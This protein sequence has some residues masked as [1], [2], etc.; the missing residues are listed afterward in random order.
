MPLTTSQILDLAAKPPDAGIAGHCEALSRQLQREQQQRQAS[1]GGPIGAAQAEFLAAVRGAPTGPIGD[2]VTYR[3]PGQAG[4]RVT[5]MPKP[6]N[7]DGSLVDVS[8]F[9]LNAADVA[10]LSR[11]PEPVQVTYADAEQLSMLAA[12]VV[13]PS[14]VRLVASLWEPVKAV[15][16]KAAAE[17]A[18]QQARRPHAPLPKALAVAALKQALADEVPD[19]TE[20]ERHHRANRLVDEALARRDG[21]RNG[22]IEQAQQTLRDA[23]GGPALTAV[24]QATRDF[25]SSVIATG[26]GSR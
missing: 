26:R 6:K 8:P 20:K 19:L 9:A 5:R 4:E 17:H 11:L 2:S 23:N 21:H 24:Q 1:G 15:H 7:S 18:V 10:W 16:D 25:H 22:R 13:N 12:Q 3:H 14:D